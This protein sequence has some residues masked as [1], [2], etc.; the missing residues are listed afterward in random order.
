MEKQAKQ[1]LQGFVKC[2]KEPS[3]YRKK[4]NDYLLIVF[5]YV[6][7]LLVTMSNIKNDQRVQG[8]DDYKFW[9]T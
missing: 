4:E 2:S 1:D 3:L 8:R 5:V 6:D 7:N 9:D